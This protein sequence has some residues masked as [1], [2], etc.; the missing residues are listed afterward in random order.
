MQ[1]FKILLLN[2]WLNTLNISEGI[3]MKVKI[4]ANNDEKKLEE[5]INDFAEKHHIRRIHYQASSKIA[6][7]LSE[8]SKFGSSRAK[9]TAYSALLEYDEDDY[10]ST[11]WIPQ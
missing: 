3:Q 8:V 1:A 6:M 11:D 2:I 5:Q 7:G 10:G 4:L 9:L